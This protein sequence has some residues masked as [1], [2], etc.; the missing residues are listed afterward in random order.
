MNIP[1]TLTAGQLGEALLKTL[2][3]RSQQTRHLGT[4]PSGEDDDGLD[5]DGDEE[6]D[7]R[8]DFLPLP[9]TKQQKQQQQSSSSSSSSSSVPFDGCA[10]VTTTS[11]GEKHLLRLVRLDGRIEVLDAPRQSSAAT[12]SQSSGSGVG[13]GESEAVGSVVL[14]VIPDPWGYER[15]VAANPCAVVDLPGCRPPLP[16]PTPLLFGAGQQQQQ[17]QSLHP[18]PPLSAKEVEAVKAF[19]G[20]KCGSALAKE[21]RVLDAPLHA[22]VLKLSYNGRLV[23]GG[24]VT[25]TASTTSG[26]GAAGGGGERALTVSTGTGV[27]SAR[28]LLLLD[29]TVVPALTQA[30]QLSAGAVS[31]TSQPRGLLRVQRCYLS[32]PWRPSLFAATASHNSVAAAAAAPGLFSPAVSRAQGE[33]GS[34]GGL[35]L[36]ARQVV[37]L[38]LLANNGLDGGDDGGGGDS[39]GS[40]GGKAAK[41]ASVLKVGQGSKVGSLL[42]HCLVAVNCPPPNA[43]SSSSS[44]G[45]GSGGGGGGGSE[46]GG[47]ADFQAGGEDGSGAASFLDNGLAPP[48]VPVTDLTEKA[49][50]AHLRP[51]VSGRKVWLV[52]GVADSNA[53]HPGPCTLPILKG[54]SSSEQASGVVL[55]LAHGAARATV[56]LRDLTDLGD[57]PGLSLAAS[58]SSSPASSSAPLVSLDDV[59]QWLCAAKISHCNQQDNNSPLSLSSSAGVPAE[60]SIKHPHEKLVTFLHSCKVKLHRVKSQVECVTNK[61]AS[62]P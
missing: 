59:G 31:A 56:T 18:T 17:Q 46:G 43:S 13:N 12:A 58:P 39:G 25:A 2:R 50:L 37:R 3:D 28:R 26:G 47:S 44:A 35:V 61:C 29:G 21:V 54:T 51:S 38:L 34:W 19:C 27:T 20:L 33:V 5:L 11:A 55:K 15:G 24:G 7:L 10:Y 60:Q 45:G 52:F 40:A 22:S 62:L 53:N 1:L 57:T 41:K 16:P 9:L 6:I 48:P 49:R 30:Q 42:T 36:G 14:A 4:D 23:L 32:N 8:V